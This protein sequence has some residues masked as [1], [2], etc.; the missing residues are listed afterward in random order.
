MN[1]LDEFVIEYPDLEEVQL[2]LACKFPSVSEIKF[3]NCAG[4]IDGIFIWMLT[5]LEEDAATAGCGRWKFF[6]GRKGKFELNCQAISE[7]VVSFWICWLDY[8]ALHL[9]V[10]HSRQAICMRDWRGGC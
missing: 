2:K 1:S 10:L 3:S 5:P 8:P 7:A 6:C 4:A 9:I